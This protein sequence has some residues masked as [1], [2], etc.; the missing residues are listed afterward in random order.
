MQRAAQEEE[1]KTVH[2]I[3]LEYILKIDLVVYKSKQIELQCNFTGSKSM[4]K[5]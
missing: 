3:Q 4:T 5:K 2:R 1:A